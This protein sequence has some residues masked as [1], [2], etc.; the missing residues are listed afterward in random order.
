MYNSLNSPIPLHVLSQCKMQRGA[1]K[2]LTSVERRRI[3]KTC[4]L[5]SHP[6]LLFSVALMSWRRRR[7]SHFYTMKFFVL[8]TSGR[9]RCCP[10]YAVQ[11]C[12]APSKSATYESAVNIGALPGP[13]AISALIIGD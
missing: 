8:L 1:A 11:R 13:E 9:F 2:Y 7:Q 4:R 10:N 12:P 6:I 5:Q 3:S